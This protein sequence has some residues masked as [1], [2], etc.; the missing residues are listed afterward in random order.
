MDTRTYELMRATLDRVAPGT[1]LREG[2][3]YIL[4]AR[5]G[6]LVVIGAEDRV[7]KLCNGGFAVDIT[8]TPQRLFELA[9]MD[10]AI[11]L[12]GECERILKANVH[13]VPDHRLPTSETGMRHRTAERVSLQTGALVISVSARRDVVSLYQHGEKLTLEAI[14]VV[15]A[16][17]NQA[18]QTLQRYR[19]RLDEVSGHLAALEFED[20]VTLSDVAT[21]IQRSEMLHRVAREV[22][23]YIA[24]LGTEGRLVRLQADELML[25]TDE[26]YL[27]LL[28]DYSPEAGPRKITALRAQVGGLGSEQLLDAAIVAGMLGLPPSA[29]VSES[30]VQPKGYRILRRVP[31]LPGTVVNRL[32]ER[33]ETLPALLVATVEQLDEVDGVGARRAR[34]IFDGLRRLKD[35]SSI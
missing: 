28:R 15:L 11:V 13:L 14:D 23:R 6:A 21:V 24:E 2:L 18:L 25:A 5:S 1:A 22:G 26:D 31:G 20:A 29:E 19:S 3:D 30:H 10:G 33:F 35:H 27:S 12:D 9:K 16:K 32:I 8:F 7:E 4:S 17:A 34:T